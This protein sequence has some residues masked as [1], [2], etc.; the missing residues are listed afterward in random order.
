MAKPAARDRASCTGSGVKSARR[1]AREFALQGLYQWLLAGGH[2]SPTSAPSSPRTPDFDKADAAY[3]RALLDGTHRRGGGAEDASSR[4]CS[5]ARPSEL[6]PVERG[7]LLIGAYE[8]KHA[9][10]IPYRVVINEAVELA[11]SFGGT[12]GHKYVN[13]VLDKL[14]A[15]C[16]RRKRERPES[17]AVR[18]RA[19]P[20]LLRA[21]ET[22]GARVRHRRRLRAPRPARRP[23]ARGHHRHARRGHATSFPAPTPRRLGHKS[24][25][26]NLSDLA[27]MGADPRWFLLALALPEADEAWLAAF[28][29]G[30]FA[31]ADAHRIEL[32]GGDTTR[33]PR[34]ITIT[35]IGTLPPGLR[36]PP[37]RGSRRRRPVGLRRDR[38]SGARPRAPSRPGDVARCR[39]RAVRRA[40]RSARAARRARPAAARGRIRGDRRVRR[41][42]RGPRAHRGALEGRRRGR[43]CARCHGPPRSQPCPTSPSPT[44]ASSAAATTTSSRSPRRR[45]ARR[46]RARRPRGGRRGHPHRLHRRRLGRGPAARRAASRSSLRAAGSI[47][48]D[49]RARPWTRCAP[50]GRRLPALAPGAFRR[51]RL[52]HRALAVRARAPSARCSR[53]PLYAVLAYWLAPGWVAARDRGVLRARR[54]G[55]RPHRARPRRRRPRRH[56]LGRDRRVPGGA[57]AHARRTLLWQA[58]A[59]FAF[60]FFDIAKPPPIRQIDRARQ[61]RV[62]RDARRRRSG[63]LY[64]SSSSPWQSGSWTEARWL[65]RSR[66]SPRSS[67]PG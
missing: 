56:E 22:P 23:R 45:E 62:R 20:A 25:A 27:A 10:D 32:V 50:A 7:M 8:L 48:S 15:S 5:T 39:R 4:R 37:R 49:D 60:R 44:S 51:A 54:L 38:R 42:A 21:P 1:R 31:L 16:G 24:L 53:F 14:A 67:A 2:A 59:F 29:A 9:P 63:V 18:V 57:A 34:T 58:A 6:S 41:P 30:M 66:R 12:D 13:G 64:R 65:K 3:F 55:L 35:A 52:R 46:R 43:L 33:G 28:A 40:P 26:V 36:A 61:G 19:H 17:G 47:T 11:K